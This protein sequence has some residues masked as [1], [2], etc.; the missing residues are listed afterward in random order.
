MSGWFDRDS[1]RRSRSRLGLAAAL[2]LIVVITVVATG[3]GPAI[4]QPL[5]FNHDKHVRELELACTFCHERVETGAHAGLPDMA[6]C[7]PCHQEQLTGSAEEAALLTAVRE[8]RPLV[9]RKLF[10]LPWHVYY[11]HARH[12][13]IAGLA[14]EGCHGAIGQMSVVP[15]RPLIR[16]SMNFC[17]DCHRRSDASVDCVA[18]HR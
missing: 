3:N 15:R 5:A 2:L 10:H 1:W 13:G 18:C 14:C 9:F 17:L 8:E 12:V 4:D 16:V 7:G 6:T 11:S